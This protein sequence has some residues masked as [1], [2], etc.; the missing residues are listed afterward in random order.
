M[1]TSQERRHTA[2]AER[3]VRVTL[4]GLIFATCLWGTVVVLA[5]HYVL[6]HP[7]RHISSLF[8][9]PGTWSDVPAITGDNGDTVIGQNHD[10]ALLGDSLRFHLDPTWD[11]HAPP[12]TRVFNWSK[13]ITALLVLWTMGLSYCLQRCQKSGENPAT[14]KNECWS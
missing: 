9:P 5:G 12:T 10:S 11:I 14:S 3:F 13:T 6:L 2:L 7:S 1:S 8:S 4:K